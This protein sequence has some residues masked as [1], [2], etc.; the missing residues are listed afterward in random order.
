MFY[1]L[2]IERA[3]KFPDKLPQLA[4]D[5]GGDYDSTTYHPGWEYW[6]EHS[7]IIAISTSMET[8]LDMKSKI[9]SGQM[10]IK[11]FTNRSYRLLLTI[12]NDET[13]LFA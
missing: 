5:A 4:S 7:K 1:T 10:H 8:L 13:Q 9:E 12:S 2:L 6:E 11:G 3:V